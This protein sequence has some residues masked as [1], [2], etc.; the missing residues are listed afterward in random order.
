MQQVLII[1]YIFQRKT[2]A[3]TM[4]IAVRM[5]SALFIMVMLI[6]NVS[7]DILVMGSLVSVN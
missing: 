5:Q 2:L 7:M 1:A 6:V 3:S 4:G